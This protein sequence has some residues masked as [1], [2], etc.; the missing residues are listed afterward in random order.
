MSFC[1]RCGHIL[2]D[3]AKFCGN[4]GGAALQTTVVSS[5]AFPKTGMYVMLLSLG[6]C[7]P[8]VAAG[9][10]SD[11][12]G[13]CDAEALQMVNSAPI[14]VAWHLRERTAIYLAQALMEYGMEI[15]VY[16][17]QGYR[18]LADDVGG[19]FEADGTITSRAAPYFGMLDDKCR[20]PQSLMKRWE[21]PYG[22]EGDQPPLFCAL[23]A[24]PRKEYARRQ[25][26]RIQPLR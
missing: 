12:C 14:T 19:V 5:S 3:D 1:Q 15:S 18:A 4:C 6:C 16:D 25:V 11:L 8:T 17:G 23:P 10:V 26:K 24:A 13:Y 7:A 20:I 22:F 9:L 2:A 21:Y